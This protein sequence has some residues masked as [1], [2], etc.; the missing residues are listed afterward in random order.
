MDAKGMLISFSRRA[1][2]YKRSNFIFT[3]K[4]FIEPLIDDNKLQIVIVTRQAFRI[5]KK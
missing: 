3:E 5:L 2:P 4:K 1:T